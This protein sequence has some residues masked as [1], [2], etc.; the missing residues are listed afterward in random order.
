MWIL[1]V[2]KEIRKGLV[3]FK[4]AFSE[5]DLHSI[6]DGNG[7]NG[8]EC[9]LDLFKGDI[10]IVFKTSHRRFESGG[11]S[12][13]NYDNKGVNIPSKCSNEIDKWL[14]F[15]SFNI[16]GFLYE[17]NVTVFEFVIN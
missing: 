12:T 10:Q 4:F 8:N 14:V 3:I 9:F 16:D 5:E 15:S 7:V 1:S 11:S 6:L 2:V 17:P 13:G